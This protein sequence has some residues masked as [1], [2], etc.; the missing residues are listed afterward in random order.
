MTRL[1]SS[2]FAHDPTK[3]YDS[4]GQ[5]RHFGQAVRKIVSHHVI[6]ISCV[7]TR[8]CKTRSETGKSKEMAI[9][10]ERKAFDFTQAVSEN[11]T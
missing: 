2:H 7:N 10:V 1:D 9:L 6:G 3:T 5:D 8:I 11:G 4:D